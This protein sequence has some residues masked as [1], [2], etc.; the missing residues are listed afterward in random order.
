MGGYDLAMSEKEVGIIHQQITSTRVASISVN[1]K[2]REQLPEL[3]TELKEKIP[4]EL[5]A[6]PAFC[7]IN[8]ITSL[9]EDYDAEIGFPISHDFESDSLKT[10]TMPAMGVLTLQH[11]DSLENIGESYR[12]LFGFAYDHGLISDE[13]C[14]EIYSQDGVDLENEIEL[15]FVIHNW[16]EVFKEHL[17]QVLG[18]DISL[19]VY[20]G[21]DKLEILGERE[22]RFRWVKG[23]IE[24]LEGLG[25]E[26]ERYEIL[27]K[28][29]HVFPQNQ[30][31]KLREV[32]QE[33]RQRTDDGLEA[34]DAVISFMETDPG[35]GEKPRTEGREMYSSKNPRDPKAYEEA[36]TEAER[37]K[38]YCFCPVIRDYLDRG[39]SSTYC[40]CGSGWYRQQ[41]EGAIGKPVKLEIMKSILKG[42]YLCE[43]KITL[44]E[45][46]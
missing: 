8:F 42:D 35:W 11:Q 44:P 2:D 7:Q 37:K 10:R 40:Y 6:G 4:G 1:L 43:F 14:L 21:G 34:V 29:A 13:F 25:D 3:F 18:D 26:L 46:L 22:E 23:A 28:C 24:R 33:T 30:I 12:Q 17:Q 27:S 38:A 41:W 5:I 16:N 31:N 20:G 32:Y 15:R 36:E 19:K 39:L 9:T 45:D